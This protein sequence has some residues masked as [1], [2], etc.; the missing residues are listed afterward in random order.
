MKTSNLTSILSAIGT[1]IAIAIDVVVPIGA[2]GCGTSKS[3]STAGAAGANL[4]GILLVLQRAA[5]KDSVNF[6][7][8]RRHR[9]PRSRH[10]PSLRRPGYKH[11]HRDRRP[12]LASFSMTGDG[13]KDTSTARGRRYDS[14][15]ALLVAV[16]ERCLLEYAKTFGRPYEEY[17]ANWGKRP[18]PTPTEKCAREIFEELRRAYRKAKEIASEIE[19]ATPRPAGGKKGEKVVQAGSSSALLHA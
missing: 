8:A 15:D 17:R 12:R 7:L 9:H 5:K 11:C 13:R 1:I 2:G 14:L 6:G 18:L 10:R 4:A 16:R 19:L 3:D